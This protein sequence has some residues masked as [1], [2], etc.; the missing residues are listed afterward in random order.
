MAS[1]NRRRKKISA[2]YVLPVLGSNLVIDR[3]T[4]DRQ[5]N[6]LAPYTGGSGFFL[7]V[8]FATSQAALLV[9]G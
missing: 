2:P 5:T 1:F 9:G 4:E 6:S 7:S 8:K 3:Q